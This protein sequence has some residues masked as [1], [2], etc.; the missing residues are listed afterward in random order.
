MLLQNLGSRTQVPL[1]AQSSSEAKSHAV[2]V[3]E[4]TGHAK[5]MGARCL[6]ELNASSQWG[7]HAPTTLSGAEHEDMSTA[8]VC[9]DP[10][11]RGSSHLRVPAKFPALGL[12]GKFESGMVRV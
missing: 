2:M 11:P 10:A 8:H 4:T 6:Y 3:S 1:K 5:A 7:C 12:T 9:A